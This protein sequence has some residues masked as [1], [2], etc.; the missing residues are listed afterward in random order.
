[1]PQLGVAGASGL[2]AV[3]PYLIVS[4]QVGGV[5]VWLVGFLLSARA[6]AKA[7]AV[8]VIHVAGELRQPAAVG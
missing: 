4:P 6:I 2:L 5:V 1:M 3:S 7:A 8:E